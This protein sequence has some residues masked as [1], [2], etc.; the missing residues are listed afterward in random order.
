MRKALIFTPFTALFIF[1]LSGCL[2]DKRYD[3]NEMGISIM[4]IKAVALTEASIS[5]VVKGITGQAAAVVVGGPLI[6]LE[7]SQVASADVHV[8]LAYDQSLVTAAGLTPLPA[9]TFSLNTL[10][11]VIAAGSNSIQNLKLSV[12][13]SNVL[14][15]N[16]IYG[17][18][19]KITSVDQGYQIAANQSTVVIAFAIKNKY[20]GVYK[21]HGHHNRVPYTFDYD[22]E[23]YLITVGPNSVIFYWPEVSSN[24]HP[25]GVGVGS[26]SWYGASI[27]P[28]IVFDPVTDLVTNVYNNPPNA[29]VITRFTGAGSR[30]SKYNPATK[31][32]TVDWNYNGNPLRAFFDDLTYK[33]PRP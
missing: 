23:I 21:L 12:T 25:I 10:N 17:V 20:D 7:T 16:K 4:D 30:I 19:F 6:T 15:P 11:P 8:T 24:G 27:S 14:D 22:T 31:A 28:V 18:G 13:N 1:I 29:T 26:T 5:P 32:I 2:K 33:G 3:N 9:G